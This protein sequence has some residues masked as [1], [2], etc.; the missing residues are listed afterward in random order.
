LENTLNDIDEMILNMAEEET[1]TAVEETPVVV[2]EKGKKIP[3]KRRS[4]P[5]ILWKKKI[6]TFKT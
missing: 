4:L 3:K 2:H 5:K 6:S 1:A